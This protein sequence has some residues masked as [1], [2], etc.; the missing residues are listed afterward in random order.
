DRTGPHSNSYRSAIT[1]DHS[2]IQRLKAEVYFDGQ[3]GVNMQSLKEVAKE[4][5]FVSFPLSLRT[6]FQK[7]NVHTALDY[8]AAHKMA[9]V[10]RRCCGSASTLG[11]PRGPIARRPDG[12]YFQN[13]GLGVMDLKTPAAD[14]EVIKTHQATVQ[15][16]A[17]KCFGTDDPS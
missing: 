8:I 12:S 14:P 10:Y 16:A 2:T 7:Y 6:V 5:G 17:V 3:G 13:F 1:L 11:S 15:L 4:D 9:D